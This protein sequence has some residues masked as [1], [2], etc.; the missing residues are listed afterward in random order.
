MCSLTRQTK[1]KKK[2][3]IKSES[4][5]SRKKQS[6]NLLEFLNLLIK[7]GKIDADDDKLLEG[8]KNKEM[9]E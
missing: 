9:N 6:A 8:K 5:S 4:D 7:G 2:E 1:R 3:I